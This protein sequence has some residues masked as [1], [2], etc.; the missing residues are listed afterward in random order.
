MRYSPASRHYLSLRSKYSPQHPVLKWLTA[1]LRQL[2]GFSVIFLFSE[3]KTGINSEK[4]VQV[5]I[6]KR[7]EL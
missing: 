3:V 4:P 7:E 5:L 2:L 6:E 1:C